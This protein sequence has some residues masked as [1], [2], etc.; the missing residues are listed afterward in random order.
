MERLQRERS[1][2]GRQCVLL[3]LFVSLLVLTGVLAQL[4]LQEKSACELE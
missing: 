4:Y 2:F 3:T 1:Q